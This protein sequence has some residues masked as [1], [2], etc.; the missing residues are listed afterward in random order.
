MNDYT[1]N[2]VSFTNHILER[3]VE[4]TMNKTGS[5]MKQYLAQNEQFVKEKLLMLY[6][7]AEL[8][9]SGK[10]KEHN[11]THFYINKDG[12]IIVVDKE[13]KKLITVYK[14]DLELDSEFNKMYVERIKNK[15]TEI[16][17]KLTKMDEELKEKKKANEETIADLQQEIVDLKEKIDY[18]NAKITSLKQEDDL[19]MKEYSML[20]KEL[21]H[22]IEKFVNAKVF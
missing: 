15:V 22:K 14:A 19:A 13:G 4:R 17:D 12:W 10:I 6:N 16:N 8:L 3:F 7:S 18:N 20:E 9:W 5:E 21:Q 1:L 2:D 11:F